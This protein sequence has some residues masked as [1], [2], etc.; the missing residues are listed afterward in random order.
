MDRGKDIENRIREIGEAIYS[1]S[2]AE[3]PSAFDRSRWTG[4]ALEWAMKDEHFKVRLFRFIDV[5]PSL[6]SNELVVRVLKEYFSDDEEAHGILKWGIKGLPEKGLIPSMAG[7]AIRQ[8]VE[9]FARQFIAG[10]DP[11]DALPA[12][13]SLRK[14]GLAFGIDILGEVVVSEKEVEKYISRYVELISDLAP[15]ISGWS[16][17]DNLDRDDKGAIPQLNI[18][19]KISSLYSQLD[20][21]DWGGSL[22]HAK[23]NLIPIFRKARDADASITLDMEHYYIKGITLAIF[24]SILEEEEFRKLPFAG[25]AIQTYLRD[26]K[27]DLIDL[28][29]WAKDRGRKISIRLVKGA[30]WDY[31]IAVNRQRAW[32]VPVY[33]NKEETDHNYEELT[34][35]L[36]ENTSFVSPAIA[37]HN[38]RSISHAIAAAETQDLPKEAYEFQMLYGMAEPVRKAVQD[39]GHR[40]RIYTPVGELIPGMSYLVRR[41]LE[42]TSNESFLRKS[43]SEGAPF[44]ELMKA[45]EQPGKEI[46]KEEAPFKNEPP[47]DFSKSENRKKMGEALKK[48]RGDFNK[49]Y[50]LYIDN[51]E[52]WK[53]EEITSV[54]PSS[55]S[56]VVGTVSMGTTADADRAIDAAK[57]ALEEWRATSSGERAEYLFKAA[58]EFRKRRFELAALE[59][60][61][62]GKS[63]KEADGD[64]TEAIDYLEF[65]GREMIRL[66]ESMRLGTCPGEINEYVYEPRGTGA[67]I[68]PWNFP[69]AIATGMVSAGIV[70]GNCVIFKPS[71]LSPVTGWRLMEVF[72]NAGLP[73]GV[74]QFLNGPGRKVGQH[75]VSHPDIDF[76]TFTGSRDVGLKIV[77]IAGKTSPRQ[78]N[79]KKVVAEMGG[80]NAII[81]DDTADVDEAV[82]G[83]LESALGYQGQK[84]SACSRV[85]VIG[86]ISEE[87]SERLREAMDS[88]HIGPPENPG[89]FMGPMIDKEALRK[90]ESYIARG[91]EAGREILCN[92]IDGDGYFTGAALFTDVDPRSALAQEEIFG[93]VLSIMKAGDIDE[94]LKIANSTTY[95]LTGGIFSRNPAHIENIRN[96]LRVGNLYINR[97]ITGAIV[98]RQPFGGFGMSGVGSKA[99]GPDYLLQFMNPRSISENTMRKGFS[100][101]DS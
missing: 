22:E 95:A 94:A 50:P 88:I 30:Y 57:T 51:E 41:L 97:Q 100:P 71:G 13:E 14:D 98:G 69:L 48:V 66:G 3:V 75:L 65:Y 80:K 70:T 21:V 1:S 63:W 24:K 4:K 67:V 61:E 52:I 74:L 47:L 26:S 15:V 89:N 56:E 20:P 78:R 11:A 96:N 16:R 42:N 35:I 10:K 44:E 68:S 39:M 90:T 18:S 7:K 17:N 87:F 28:I 27:D 83:V 33:L 99:G 29:A 53:E 92:K 73:K 32:P 58:H 36:M 84:C 82:K 55:P 43:F 37:T 25:V 101:M 76:I 31:E 93:P 77:E 38:M 79:V 85:I 9:T 6:K 81:I 60:Y 46:E 8:N 54:N 91:R 5:L 72:R 49:K 86:D 19:L 45:P 2:K 23:N 40:V 34:K 12:L 64:I 59:V 62:A